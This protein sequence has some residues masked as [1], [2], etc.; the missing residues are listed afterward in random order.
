MDHSA[1]SLCW[2]GGSGATERS[3]PG[4]A[5]QK[6]R[7]ANVNYVQHLGSFFGLQLMAEV[8]CWG[9]KRLVEVVIVQAA[10]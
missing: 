10:K 1:E 9:E 6:Q 5:L 4:E 7:A 3:L 2:G 8:D